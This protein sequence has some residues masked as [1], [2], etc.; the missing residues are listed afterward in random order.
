MNLKASFLTGDFSSEVTGEDFFGFKELGLEKEF[1]ELASNVPLQLLT[2][3]FNGKDA[4]VQV[5]TKV[6]QPEEFEDIIYKKVTKETVQY[7]KYCAL[8]KPLLQK[9]V[10]RCSAYY[11]KL[12]R[13]K[14]ADQVPKN[15]ESPQ[16]ALLEDDEFPKVKGSTRSRLPPTGKISTNYKKK[17]ASELFILPEEPVVKKTNSSLDD[18]KNAGDTSMDVDLFGS[19]INH[20]DNGF[21][22][23][24]APVSSF[25]LS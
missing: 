3:H 12:L 1:G 24:E 22:V 20:L 15:Y 5:K 6:I 9:A 17:P 25:S 19:P 2:F 4:D 14:N 13:S 21:D 23:E 10:D 11:S 8:A 7:G 18:V 16:L